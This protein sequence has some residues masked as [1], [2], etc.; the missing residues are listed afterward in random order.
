MK[1]KFITISSE[2]NIMKWNHIFLVSRESICARLFKRL[3]NI[4]MSF[5]GIEI[6]N[7]GLIADA[8]SGLMGE[9]PEIYI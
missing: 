2:N 3:K 6:D 7:I 1:R 9:D 5:K 8:I 4:Y